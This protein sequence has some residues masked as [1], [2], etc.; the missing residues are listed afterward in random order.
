MTDAD[1]LDPRTPILVGVG[2]AHDDVEAA[3]LM[4]RAAEA[5]GADAAPSLLAALDRISVTKGTWSYPDPGRL[6]AERIG[7]SGATTALYELGIPQQTVIDEAMS[8]LLAGEID[9]ALVVGGEAKA[10]DARLRRRSTQADA[11]GLATVVRGDGEV[12]ETDQGDVEPDVHRHPEGDLVDP[13]EIEAG[14]WAPV[15]QYALIENALGAAEGRSPSQLRD[16]VAELQARCNV[17][18]RANPE[19]AF[20]R[21]MTAAEIREFGPDN[22]PMS[23][24]YAKWHVTQWTVDQAAA[25][26][27]CTVD[28]AQRHGVPRE[29]WLF[30]LVGLSSSHSLPLTR[31]RQLHRWPAMQI[32]GAAAVERLGHPLADCDHVDLYS[33]FPVAIRVQQRELDLP[34]DGVPTVTGGMTFAGGPFNNYVF[35]ST[36]AMAR[37]LR[38][39]GG[40]GLVTTVSGLLTKP[41]LAVWSAEPDGRRPLIA[42]LGA[43]AAAETPSVVARTD[44]EGE[45]VVATWTVTHDGQ[46]PHEVIVIADA[47]DGTRVIGR[48]DAQD[49]IARALAEGLSGVTSTGTWPSPW[50]LDPR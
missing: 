13:V 49:L 25:L 38:A 36:V 3:E 18:A 11:A 40:R 6:V 43:Q 47:A 4:A 1:P 12:W 21:P 35:Q 17:V 26:L 29:R 8:A 50:R 31:R 28:A 24:P 48:S 42:D 14:L 9:V 20:P 33:C 39:S 34:L 15:D 32:L 41:G 30:P 22:R 7:A 45:A 46:D 19:A 44:H 2:T 27:L 5:A 10:R 23:F 16:D 37:R